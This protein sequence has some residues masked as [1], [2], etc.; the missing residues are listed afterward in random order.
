MAKDNLVVSGSFSMSPLYV[1]I[2]LC[3]AAGRPQRVECVTANFL[4]GAI[5]IEHGLGYDTPGEKKAYDI[6]IAERDRV[7]CFK[8]LRARN[9]VSVRYTPSQLAEV[10]RLLVHRSDSQLRAAVD[11]DDSYVTHIYRR[12]YPRNRGFWHSDAR[13]QA[14]AHVFLERGI[15]VG[16]THWGPVLYL[17]KA[18]NQTIPFR[19][20]QGPEPAEGQ[21]TAGRGG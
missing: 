8:K 14:V 7:F 5:H 3:D 6:A 4:S 18:S 16:Q 1:L 12:I 13:M 11:R 20:A 19:R 15:L 21:R 10:R 17:E 2:T 9:N